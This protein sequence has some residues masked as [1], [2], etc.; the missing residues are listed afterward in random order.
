MSITDGINRTDHG[1][2]RDRLP[3]CSNKR[4]INNRTLSTHAHTKPQQSREGRSRGSTVTRTKCFDL[5]TWWH[6]A[7]V[8]LNRNGVTSLKETMCDITCTWW[9]INQSTRLSFPT[10]K[11]AQRSLARRAR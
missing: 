9:L 6:I 10:R 11:R 7:S 4:P 5:A 1:V 3:A 2:S 8:R